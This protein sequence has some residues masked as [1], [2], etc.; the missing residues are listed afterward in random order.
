[1]ISISNKYCYFYFIFIKES[2]KTCFLNCFHKNFKQHNCFQEIFIEPQIR[3]LEGCS[4]TEDWSKDAEK[5]ALHNM[6]KWHLKIH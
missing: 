1:M 2:W 6:N 3:I 5:S 4:D